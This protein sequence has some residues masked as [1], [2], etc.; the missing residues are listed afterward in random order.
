MPQRLLPISTL[1]LIVLFVL[2]APVSQVRADTGV[3]H[4]HVMVDGY[5][6][7][8]ILPNGPAMIGPN[9][10]IIRLFNTDHRPLAHATVLLAPNVVTAT[11]AGHS[12]GSDGGHDAAGAQGHAD[13]AT[14]GHN[15][16]HADGHTHQAGDAHIDTIMTQL[17]AGTDAGHYTGVIHFDSAGAWHVQLQFTAAGADHAGSFA[18]TVTEPARDWRLLGAF[19]GANALIIMTA[20]ILK[21]RFP[22]TAKHTRGALTSHPE[23]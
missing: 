6:A 13:A 5:D 7:E 21:R 23:N 22:T 8:L 4:T 15:A 9:L 2:F 16:S 12:H 18:V 11:D 1:S 17:E 19:G 14:S 3:T 20:G 10:V